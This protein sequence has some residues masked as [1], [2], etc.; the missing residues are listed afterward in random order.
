MTPLDH[1]KN[2]ARWQERWE[3][4]GVFRASDTDRARPKAYILDMFPYPSGVGLH[5]GH[6]EGFTATDIVSRWRRMQGW[7]VLHPMGWDAFGL[8]AENYAIATGIHPARTTAAA[9]A[10]FKR[11]IKAIGLSYDWSR[12]F[13]TTDPGYL[14]WTQWIFLRLYEKGLAYRASVPINWCPKDRTGLANEEVTTAGAS[15]A[16]PPSSGAP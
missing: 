12:E 13:S 1:E 2:D 5:V 11:Q 6:P 4:A 7:N 14:R 10:T 8:P 3:A 15:A 9:I 16:G